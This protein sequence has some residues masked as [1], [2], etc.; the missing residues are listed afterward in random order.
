VRYFSYIEIAEQPQ[1]LWHHYQA[2]LAT[3]PNLATRRIL[4]AED[5]Y[6]VF[7]ELFRKQHA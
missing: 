5:I 4:Q 1:G 3:H 2:L 6:P 7:R